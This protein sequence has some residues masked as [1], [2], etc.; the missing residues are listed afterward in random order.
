MAQSDFGIGL[1]KMTKNGVHSDPP[2]TKPTK[3]AGTHAA[4]DDVQSASATP[5]ETRAAK[6]GNRSRERE[7]HP[8]RPPRGRNDA[9]KR[10]PS[11]PGL[12]VARRFT[13]HDED[14]LDTGVYER[15]S[16]SITNP[17]GSIVFKMDGA[18]VPA[19]WSQLATDIVISKY[20]RKAGL[21][22][23]KDKGETSV[24][25]VVYRIAHTIRAAGV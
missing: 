22:G 7:A 13:R 14:P 16:S 21:F 12:V 24:R 9:T 23:D 18:Q 8:P 19:S 17:D 6:N 1:A 3:Q 5:P 10:T 4:I 25:Q 2:P 15:R 11:K 20:F